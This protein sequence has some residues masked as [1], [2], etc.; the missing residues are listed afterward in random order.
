MAVGIDD[1]V[2]EAC[3]YLCS[4]RCRRHVGQHR[5]GVLG[6]S[7]VRFETGDPLVSGVRALSP[8]VRATVN[9]VLPARPVA[10]AFGDVGN[11]VVCRFLTPFALTLLAILVRCVGFGSVMNE[12]EVLFTD[13]DA[14]YHIRRVLYSL[15]TQLPPPAFDSYLNFPAGGQPG[16]HS[17]DIGLPRRG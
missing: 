17:G 15:Y 6:T 2:V 16:E 11:S 7:T 13:P 9:P 3:A 8:S 1:G 5:A 4:G 10:T 12:G 14:Y